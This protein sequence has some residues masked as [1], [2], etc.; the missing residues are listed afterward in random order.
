MKKYSNKLNTDTFRT[1]HN[2]TDWLEVIIELLP[3]IVAITGIATLMIM[4]NVV[5][6]ILRN[7]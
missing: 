7:S 2:K 5:S 3:Y 1:T 4:L 6:E